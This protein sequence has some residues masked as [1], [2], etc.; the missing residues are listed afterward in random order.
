MVINVITI[1]S[2]VKMVKSRLLVPTVTH[3]EEVYLIHP[4]QDTKMNT[5]FSIHSL[6][7]KLQ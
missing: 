6:D 5:K 4:V 1:A 2:F 3:F 7:R